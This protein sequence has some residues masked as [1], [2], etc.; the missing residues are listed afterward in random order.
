MQL[1]VAA[2]QRLAAVLQ[3]AEQECGDPQH[4]G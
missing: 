3:Q 2:V 1:L 4:G